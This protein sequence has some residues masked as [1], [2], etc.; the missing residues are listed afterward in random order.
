MTLRTYQLLKAVDH[1]RVRR[2]LAAPLEI[3][4]KRG[5]VTIPVSGAIELTSEGRQAVKLRKQGCYGVQ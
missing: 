1:G 2:K 5:L 3:L 4:E